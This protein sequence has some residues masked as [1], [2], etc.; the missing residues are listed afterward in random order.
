MPRIPV[1]TTPYHTIPRQTRHFKNKR[2]LILRS[3]GKASYINGGQFVIAWISPKGEVETFA[4]EMLQGAVERVLNGDELR[5]EAKRI[6]DE[7]ERRREE[8]RLLEEKGEQIAE[9]RKTPA[10]RV[11]AEDDAEDDDEDDEDNE[12]EDPDKTMVDD[13]DYITSRLHAIG[14]SSKSPS[15]SHPVLCTPMND[16]VFHTLQMPHAHLGSYYESRFT[17]IQ[18]TTCKIVVKAWIKVIEPKKQVRFPYNKGEEGRP[19]WWP[20]GVRHREPDHLG[21]TGEFQSCMSVA[22]IVE[23]IVLLTAIVR[24]PLI[25]VSRLELSTAEAGAFISPPRLA[26]LREVYQVA[27]EEERRRKD[28]VSG[29]VDESD[30]TIQLPANPVPATESPV[31]A[32]KRGR[33]E[34]T[35]LFSSDRDNMASPR[36]MASSYATHSQKRAKHATRTESLPTT[37]AYSHTETTYPSAPFTYA[38]QP[39]LSHWREQ[40]MVTPYDSPAETSTPQMA[41][42]LQIGSWPSA[43]APALTS[44]T[45]GISQRRAETGL[46]IPQPLQRSHSYG[47]HL[48]A[49]RRPDSALASPTDSVHSPYPTSF[50]PPQPVFTHQQVIMGY[51]QAGMNYGGPYLGDTYHVNQDSRYP[52]DV[53]GQRLEQDAQWVATPTEAL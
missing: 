22:D 45:P 1:R 4:S 3:L 24:S 43:Q 21:K 19:N 46:A 12:E 10:K 42:E 7:Q 26:I 37:L 23:R 2:D 9:V 14:S 48:Q 44:R 41:Q 30:I 35:A 13:D 38:P 47:Q 25:S 11:A 17:N 33:Q 32:K 28:A 20:E 29:V 51:P 18:Q 49:P 39:S 8:M 27:R 40:S 53:H 16:S 15:P 50:Y 6:G 52:V 34:M 36:P 5:E 31:A